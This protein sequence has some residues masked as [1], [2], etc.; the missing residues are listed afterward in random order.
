MSKKKVTKKDL[1]FEFWNDIAIAT[2]NVTIKI[3]KFEA[4]IDKLS[5][6]IEK[7]QEKVEEISTI[8]TDIHYLKEVAKQVAND[9]QDQNK[10]RATPDTKQKSIK[11]RRRET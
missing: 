7:I 10:K 6:R 4:K 2:Q 11:K 1:D 5:T 3:D 9:P 8:K